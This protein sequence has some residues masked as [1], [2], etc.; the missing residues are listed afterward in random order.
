MTWSLA[1]DETARYERDGCLVVEGALDADDLARLDGAVREVTEA[2]LGG[3]DQARVIEMEPGGN[4]P[5]A[6]G[7]GAEGDGRPRLRRIIDPYERHEA[8]RAV[9]HDPR[10]VDRVESLL[11]PDLDLQHSKLNMKPARVGSP[12]HWH[13]DLAYYPHTNE[14][15]LAVLVYIDDATE[16]NGCLQVLPGLN[17]RYLDHHH[18]DGAFAGRITEAV[19]PEPQPRTLPAPAGSAIFL[20][21]LTPHSSLPNQ[22]GADRRTLILAYRAGDAYPLYYGLVTAEDEAVRR[23]VRGRRARHARFGGPA[24]IVP[25]I[26]GTSSLYEIQAGRPGA[27]RTRSPH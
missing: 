20:H 24:P 27:P 21:G 26:D 9:A 1:S 25:E 15:V 23:P 19:E 18:P 3:E 10:I 22:S 2:A 13:Q 4:G 12:V 7:N 17:R 8:F 11:G 16:A 5:G 14:G 6:E